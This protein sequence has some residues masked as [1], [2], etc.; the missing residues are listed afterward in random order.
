MQNQYRAAQFQKKIQQLKLYYLNFAAKE[1]KHL[2]LFETDIYITKIKSF[3]LL[4]KHTV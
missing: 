4:L 3:L 2:L 1:Q